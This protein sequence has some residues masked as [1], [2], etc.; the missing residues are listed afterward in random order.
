MTQLYG[1]L[2]AVKILKTESTMVVARGWEEG[3]IWIYGLTVS[4]L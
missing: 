3:K 2:G 1:I 4:I